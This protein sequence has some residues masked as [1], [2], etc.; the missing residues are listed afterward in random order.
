ML[1]SLCTSFII[2]KKPDPFYVVLGPLAGLVSIT[3]GCNS[4]TTVVAIIVGIIGALVAI[5]KGTKAENVI[6]MSQL[7]FW[8]ILNPRIMFLDCIFQVYHLLMDSRIIDDQYLL[9]NMVDISQLM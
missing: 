5:I 7:D 2:Y 9:P 8:N 1:T 6:Q 3:A 4:M